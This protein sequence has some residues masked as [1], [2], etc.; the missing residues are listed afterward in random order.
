M[1]T[2]A[3][4]V[5]E[6]LTRHDAFGEPLLPSAISGPIYPPPGRTLCKFR[7]EH[8]EI[9]IDQWRM[10]NKSPLALAARR[11]LCDAES[12]ASSFRVVQSTWPRHAG[13]RALVFAPRSTGSRGEVANSIL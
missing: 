6:H 8:D 12:V 1:P 11:G 4:A 3:V 2:G 7:A 9:S 10:L 13:P 5:N